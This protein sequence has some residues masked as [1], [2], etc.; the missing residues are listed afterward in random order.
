MI[1]DTD[2]QLLM[3]KLDAFE[4]KLQKLENDVLI[5]NRYVDTQLSY[6]YHPN[7]NVDPSYW[8]STPADLSKAVRP[9]GAI[10]YIPCMYDSVEPN[11]A[12]GMV[13]SCP[14][15]SAY[16]LSQ[17]NLMDGGLPQAWKLSTTTED[18]EE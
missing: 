10:G 4:V 6:K 17:G 2:W 11:K 12:M 18:Y 15:H 5:L 3:H 8:Q 14:K 9:V 1:S 7:Q 16:A 13:C